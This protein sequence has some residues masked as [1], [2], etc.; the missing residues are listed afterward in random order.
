MNTRKRKESKQMHHL[1]RHA[2]NFYMLT[3]SFIM[4]ISSW[5][6]A[7]SSSPRSALDTIFTANSPPSLRCVASFTTTANEPG[8]LSFFPNL[9]WSRNLPL[10]DDRPRRPRAVGFLI[11]VMVSIVLALSSNA[12]PPIVVVEFSVVAAAAHYMLK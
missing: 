6:A 12:E 8:S 7:A 1:T 2:H 4:D 3:N 9:Y 10:L 11:H 5:S